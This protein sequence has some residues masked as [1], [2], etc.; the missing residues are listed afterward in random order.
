MEKLGQWEVVSRAGTWVILNNKLGKKFAESR[1]SIHPCLPPQGNTYTGATYSNYSISMYW[2]SKI[3]NKIGPLG[4]CEQ[5]LLNSKGFCIWIEVDSHLQS[6][7][8]IFNFQI[9]QKWTQWLHYTI[10]WV[11]SPEVAQ[12]GFYNQPFTPLWWSAMANPLVLSFGSP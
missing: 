11:K 10:P 9:K 1:L 2:M 6:F 8:C 3:K 12:L 7:I 4:K 5:Y